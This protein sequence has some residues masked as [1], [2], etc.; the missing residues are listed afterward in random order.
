MPQGRHLA[1]FER[2]GGLLGRAPVRGQLRRLSLSRLVIHQPSLARPLSV[3][4]SEG[5]PPG[6]LLQVMHTGS[7]RAADAH[8]LQDTG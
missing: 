7:L 1:R 3:G 6:Q 5:V 4:Q 2:R 8:R